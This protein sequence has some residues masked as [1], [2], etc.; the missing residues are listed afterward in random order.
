MKTNSAGINLIKS[1]EGCVLHTYLDAVQIPTIGYGHTG[2]D[3][4]PG[5]TITQDEAETLLRKDLEK[6]E[7]GVATLVKVTISDNAYAAL[8]CFSYNLGLNALAQSTLLK[9]LNSGDRTV[10]DEFGRWTKAGGKVLP[11]LVKRREAEKHLF[12]TLQTA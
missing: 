6:F 7:R 2:P 4:V 10:A 9:K 1:C 12:L 8:V 5:L 3:V 11:G